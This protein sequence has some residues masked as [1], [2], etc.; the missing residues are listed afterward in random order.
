M[1]NKDKRVIYCVKSCNFSNKILLL[2]LY[3]SNAKYRWRFS[4]GSTTKHDEIE[5]GYEN[6]ECLRQS[7]AKII[8]HFERRQN[9]SPSPHL[10]PGFYEGDVNN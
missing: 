8:S 5:K 4:E 10:Y 7:V 2:S 6:N 3:V 1:S 9:P